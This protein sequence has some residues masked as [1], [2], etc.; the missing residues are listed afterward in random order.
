MNLLWMALQALW[1]F[2]VLAGVGFVLQTD[3]AAR[4]SILGAHPDL[5]LAAVVLLAR[6]R[7]PLAGALAG[8]LAGLMRDGL[9][10]DRLGLH[11]FLLCTVGFLFG[12]LRVSMLWETPAASALILFL[13]GMVHQLLL[14]VF[15]ADGHW[16]AATASFLT[17]GLASAAYT[18]VLV[19]LVVYAVPRILRGRD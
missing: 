9:T 13:A 14:R 18:A 12:H 3:V 4:L 6:R 7:G 15:L 8:F 16:G 19:P 17:A 10:P 1:L 5:V 11:T 2:A